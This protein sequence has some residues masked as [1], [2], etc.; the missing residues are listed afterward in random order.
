MKNNSYSGI[1]KHFAL[2]FII[3]TEGISYFVIVPII[4]FYIWSNLNLKE[5]QVMTLFICAIGAGSLSFITTLIN[6]LIVISP[7]VKYFKKTIRGDSVGDEEYNFALKRFLH[8]PYIHSIGAF[9]RWIVGL[10]MFIFSFAYFAGLNEQQIFNLWLMV[11]INAPLGTVLYFLLTEIMTQKIYDQGIF[12]KTLP[13]ENR[14]RLHMKLFP[15]V[16]ISIMAIIMLPYLILLSYFLIF[17]SEMAVDKT[18]VYFRISVFSGIGIIGALMVSSVLSKTISSKVNNIRDFLGGIGEGDLAAY[19]KKIVVSDELSE[20]NISVYEMKENLK[21][22]VETIYKSSSE[23]KTTSADLN[24]ASTDLSDMSRELSSI[25]EETSSAYE[26]MSTSFETNLLNI[27]EQLNSSDSVK[28][29]ILEINSQSGQITKRMEMVGES[30]NEAVSHVS[31]GEKIMG[32]AV[33]SIEDTARYLQN[34]EDTISRINDVADQINLLALNA[35]I[36]A[37]RAGEHGKGFAVVADEVNK[38]ADQT[39]E[40]ANSIR[41]TISEHSKRI[42]GELKSISETTEIFKIVREKILETESVIKETGRFTDSL[43]KMNE[44][45][46]ER[47]FKLGDIANGIYTSSLE[48]QSTTNELTKAINS[49]NEISLHTT[50]NSELVKSYS[51]ILVQFSDELN[52]NIGSFQI[53][54]KHKEDK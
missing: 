16:T 41:A 28:E 49:I 5:D 37:A 3:R 42:A 19:A 44:E 50:E 43:K 11:V 26:E 54:S 1:I 20:I 13:K 10:S 12:I 27:K 52:S 8:L 17:I 7:V 2:N 38:L 40:L 24:Y 29:E 36:E 25:I 30:I 45:I 32:G 53:D 6:N 47:I 14:I 34:I 33:K 22:I 48:Q 18:Q 51:K 46:N 39:T 4:V 21:K 35:A 9:F 15:K 23:L 31:S